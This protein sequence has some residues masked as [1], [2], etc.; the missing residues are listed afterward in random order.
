MKGFYF[1]LFHFLG[2]ND[3]WSVTIS[4]RRRKKR[5]IKKGKNTETNFK[6]YRIKEKGRKRKK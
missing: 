1:S 2:L 3:I 4:G 5:V 6:R